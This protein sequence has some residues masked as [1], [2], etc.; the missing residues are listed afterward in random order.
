MKSWLDPNLK[1]EM[2]NRSSKTKRNKKPSSFWKRKPAVTQAQIKRLNCELLQIQAR[3][4]YLHAEIER[5]YI[6]ALEA[7]E[8]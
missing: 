7:L 5:L 6:R 4:R 8:P 2:Q 3:V 1:N